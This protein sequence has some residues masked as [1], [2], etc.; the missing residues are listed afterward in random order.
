M[1]Q[2]AYEMRKQF[3]IGSLFG[4]LCISMI[5]ITAT[6]QDW[7]LVWSDEFDGEALDQSKWSYMVGTGAEY[8]IPDWGN[9][10]LQYYKEENAVVA[11]GMLNIIAKKEFTG[12]K[13]YTSA[14]IRT[15]NKGDWEYCKIEFRAKMPVGKGLWAAFWML[16]T[17]NLYGGWAASGEIDIMEYLGDSPNTVHGTL[18][19]GNEYPNNKSNG[20][21]YV[22]ATGD[23]HSEFHDF[24]LEWEEGV[25]RWY[26]DSTLY[27]TLDQG[28][29]FTTGHSFPAPFNKRFHLLINL[30][31]GGNWPGFPDGTTF[32]QSFIIDYVRVYQ[33][34]ETAINPENEAASPR[35]GLRQNNPN[36][37]APHTRITYSTPFQ[38]PVSIEVFDSL[39]RLV[40]TLVGEEKLP[41]TYGID[42]DAS[43][44]PSGLYSY[45]LKAGN[46]VEVKQMVRL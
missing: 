36:P 10:E 11:D 15:L 18:H 17:D 4:M 9:A 20:T 13:S 41:G 42:F 6:G 21:D 30:A 3:S 40:R 33:R 45:R 37:F 34:V 24:A 26:V 8:G 31:V 12:G 1:D 27:Q 29:W 28:D 5:S 46:Q 19:F 25:M 7:S 2:L 16:P 38:G 22:L 35:F 23:F 32:P 14:R 39:G 43:S 44:L